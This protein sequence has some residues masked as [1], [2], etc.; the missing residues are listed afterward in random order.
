MFISSIKFK[1]P[2]FDRIKLLQQEVLHAEKHFTTSAVK[3]R[4]L[5]LH[6]QCLPRTQCL[7]H[8]LLNLA[9][10]LVHSVLFQA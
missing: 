1:E 8:E 3:P 4:A 6:V 2:S 5:V 7:P 10:I 9:L